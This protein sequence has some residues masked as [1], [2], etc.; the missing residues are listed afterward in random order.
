MFG[1]FFFYFLFM[2]NLHSLCSN[3][4][5]CWDVLLFTGQIGIKNIKPVCAVAIQLPRSSDGDCSRPPPVLNP[6]GSLPCLSGGLVS[7]K[8]TSRPCR[9]VGWSCWITHTCQAVSSTASSNSFPSHG[10]L[11]QKG[12]V[13]CNKGCVVRRWGHV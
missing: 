9:T 7:K 3:C 2:R 4:F 5:F 10:N 8:N 6:Q 11:C 1:L 12:V 13:D